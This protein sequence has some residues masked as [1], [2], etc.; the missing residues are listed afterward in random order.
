MVPTTAVMA[1]QQGRQ[2]LNGD[3]RRREHT[4]GLYCTPGAYQSATVCSTLTKV[5]GRMSCNPSPFDSCSNTHLTQ[6]AQLAI[7]ELLWNHTVKHTWSHNGISTL[8]FVARGPSWL[9]VYCHSCIPV[10]GRGCRS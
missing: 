10:C 8:A 2:A 3:R 6:P 7:H 1:I 4:G 5:P 9:Q